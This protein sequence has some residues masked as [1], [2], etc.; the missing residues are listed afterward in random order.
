VRRPATLSR[1]AIA[2]RARP[3]LQRLAGPPE[4][5]ALV[6]THVLDGVANTFVTVSLAGS[7]FFQ[8]SLDASR[9]RILLFLILTVVP[10]AVVTPLVGPL[11]ERTR[12]GYRTVVIATLAV[13]ALSAFVLVANLRSLS[14]Y[15]LV[16]VFLLLGKLYAVARAALVPVLVAG[17]EELVSAN[18]HVSQRSTVAS[19]VAAVAASALLVGV[20]A[21][22]VLLVAGVVFLLAALSARSLPRQERAAGAAPTRGREGSRAPAVVL[23]MG[24]MAV[25][26]AGI[27]F[28][29]F[30][31]AFAFKR[32]GVEPWVF[33]A[34]LAAAG[35]G[36][37]VGGQLA[38]WFRRRMA[39]EEHV[40]SACV[41]VGGLAALAS[42]VTHGRG[43]IVL[44][45]A[46]VNGAGTAGRRA[47][48]AMIGRDVTERSRARVVARCETVLQATW[49]IGAMVAVVAPLSLRVAVALLGLVLLGTGLPYASWA[50]LAIH[51]R[52]ARWLV[53]GGPPASDAPVAVV[54]LHEA[55]RL[56]RLGHATAAVVVADAAVQAAR[57]TAG[58]ANVPSE[59]AVAW[60]TSAAVRARAAAGAEPPETSREEAREV[61]AVARQIVASCAGAA[62]KAGAPGPSRVQVDEVDVEDG[63]A[64][65]GG[66]DAGVST[67]QRSSPELATSSVQ[68]SKPPRT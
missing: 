20:G 65:V 24:A 13:R 12:S 29:A 10:L 55:L 37:F 43:A 28:L 45:A 63:S 5:R 8:V 48:E 51:R 39:N 53:A 46:V 54:L 41:V 16:F 30:F 35:I 19:S 49:A 14:F 33:G 1:A 17:P 23:A 61:V 6:R 32:G 58:A 34:A 47:F 27:G 60:S 4:L 15:P 68:D 7:L 44:A 11:L 38:P 42:A 52:A 3:W 62:G 2:R 36:G 25:M 26:R 21:S 9:P 56:E 40:V 31:V 64:E 57:C 50:E 22:T 59:L 67:D 18:T 66:V